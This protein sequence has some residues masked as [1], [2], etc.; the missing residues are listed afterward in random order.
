MATFDFD[1]IN[2][3]ITVLAPDTDITI[4]E[5]INAIRDWEENHLEWGQVAEAS[6]K[7][8][9][10][11]N[12]YVAITL[13][14]LGWK[15]KFEERATPTLCVVRG[16]NLLAVDDLG[17]YVNPIEQ[18]ENVTVI[19]AQSTSA[20]LVVSTEVGLDEL[21]KIYK[22]LKTIQSLIIIK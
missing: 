22:K 7:E 12:V 16:G 19:I 4:Q 2:R 10:G 8:P 11:G 21:E 20:T 1:P 14:L 9:L 6:G 3:I 15:L 18:S 5:L 17:N 13:K